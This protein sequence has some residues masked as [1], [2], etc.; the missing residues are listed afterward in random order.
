MSE[1]QIED[2][3]GEL[4]TSDMLK[5]ALDFV[6]YLGTN[7]MMPKLVAENCWTFAYLEEA[8][9]VCVLAIYPDENGIG[10]T[11]FDNPLTSKYD[12]FQVDEHLK[13]FARAHINICTSCGGSSGCGSQPGKHITIFGKEYD[14]ICTSEVA[15]RNPDSEALKK[16]KQLIEAWKLHIDNPR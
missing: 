9:H 10:W 8:I 13:E 5:N 15:F 12:D 14:N 2:A 7:D 6:A 1:K 16:I 4:L 3:I 11:I